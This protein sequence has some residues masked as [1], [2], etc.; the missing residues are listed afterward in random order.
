V[1]QAGPTPAQCRICSAESLP[2]STA[3]ILARYDIA[4][5]RCAACGFVQTEKPYWLKE[6]YAD[7]ITHT[8]IGVVRRNI[9]L[10]RL[11]RVLL[12]LIVDPGKSFLDYGG[13]YGM[14]VRLMRDEGFDFHWHDAYC[15]NLFAKDFVAER[16]RKYELL[17][18]FE[19][20]EHLEHPWDELRTMLEYSDTI[21]LTTMILPEPCPHPD[22]WWYYGLDHGQHISFHT[23]ASL[24]KLAAGSGANLYSNGAHTHL[25]TRRPISAR[26]FG[27]ALRKSARWL[28][29]LFRRKSLL[30]DD[31][32]NSVARAARQ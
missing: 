22:E 27:F 2:F 1:T 12:P 15:Q 21:L 30:E 17:T 31:F 26:R 16:G 20:F 11:L 10:S 13:G 19:V 28:A 32:A 23:V 3:R 8:D 14:L 4:Y 24:H 29:P 5:F 25:I 7:A 6:A 9:D 18:A